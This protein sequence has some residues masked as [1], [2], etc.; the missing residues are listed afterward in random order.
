MLGGERNKRGDAT[1]PPRQLQASQN[2]AAPL[3]EHQNRWK[4]NLFGAS[5]P[6][7]H[8]THGRQSCRSTK[9]DGNVVPPRSANLPFH[10]GHPTH[11]HTHGRQNCRSTKVDGDVVPQ[12]RQICRSTKY[13]PLTKGVPPNPTNNLHW[14][15]SSPG[16]RMP[17]RL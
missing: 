9:V 15:P 8:H 1:I 6:P 4:G 10:Q 13:T 3:R 16:R 12:G 7:P 14:V 5:H 2:H 17:F 11:Q